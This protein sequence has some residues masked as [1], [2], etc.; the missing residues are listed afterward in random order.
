MDLYVLVSICELYAVDSA[1]KNT[2]YKCLLKF[3]V[4]TRSLLLADVNE[5]D[6]FNGGCAGTCVDSDGS[7]L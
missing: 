5:C 4:L 3:S 7:Y 1:R 6:I 2:F